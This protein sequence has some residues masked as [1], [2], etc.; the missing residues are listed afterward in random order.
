[1]ITQ[2]K[3]RSLIAQGEV[4]NTNVEF[5]TCKSEISKSLYESICAFLN[6]NGG[7]VLLGVEDDGTITGVNESAIDNHIKNIVNFR[8][9]DLPFLIP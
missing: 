8:T 1:M 3:I 9:P 2:E 4:R 6:R 7:D 5:K